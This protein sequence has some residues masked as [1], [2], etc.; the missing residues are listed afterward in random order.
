MGE[1]REE[2][3]PCIYPT[4]FMEMLA[5]F[6]L[7]T[8]LFALAFWSPWMFAAFLVSFAF[9]LALTI[10]FDY[11]CQEVIYL[12]KDKRNGE[13]VVEDGRG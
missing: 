9:L 2:E 10:Y 12:A 7:F 6:T 13:R 11:E 4:S 1:E 5:M 8:F 3:E